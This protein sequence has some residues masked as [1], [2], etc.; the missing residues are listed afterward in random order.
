MDEHRTGIDWMTRFMSAG[1]GGASAL[2]ALGASEPNSK[3]EALFRVGFGTFVTFCCTG[4]VL[5]LLKINP[6]V[7]A[8]LTAALVI[9]SGAWFIFGAFIVLL[10]RSNVTIA[11]W[12]VKK[13]TGIEVG[14]DGLPLA[15]TPTVPSQPP[16]G[17]GS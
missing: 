6:T 8:V 15:P 4:M 11:R 17:G 12:I 13:F 7:D 9:G 16:T 10:S 14:P 2:L 5:D 3:R 1:V